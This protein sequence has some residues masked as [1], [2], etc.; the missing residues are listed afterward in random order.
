MTAPVRLAPGDVLRLGLLGVS[1]R[2][3]RA[4]L[5][6]LGIA[7]G[8]ATMIVVT[9]IPASSQA[10][11]LRRLTALGTDTLRA[12]PLAQ[13]D[14]PVELPRSAAAMAA[15]I[16]P[17]T[18]AAAVANTHAVVRRSDRIDPDDGSGLTVLASST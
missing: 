13:Q 10:E 7:I 5:S 16:G 6:A 14:T 17:V 18:G 15:R 9:G 3:L 1:T 8:V 2:R 4:A 12:E 11:L